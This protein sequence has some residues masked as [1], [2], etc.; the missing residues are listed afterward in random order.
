MPLAIASSLEQA[1]E[2]LNSGKHKAVVLDFDVDADAFF[3]LSAKFCDHGAK[4]SR[5]DN[6][7]VIK[8]KNVD[9]PALS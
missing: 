2:M 4:I 3:A 6:H 5:H 8:L 7:F 9:I 1:Y